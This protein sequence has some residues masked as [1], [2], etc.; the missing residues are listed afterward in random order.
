MTTLIPLTPE[1]TA[2]RLAE[3][4]AVLIDIRG[5]DEFARRHIRDAISL[6]LDTFERSRLA[7][8]PAS[9]VIFTC[10][11]GNRTSANCDRLAARIDRQAYVLEGGTD[12]WV[13]A[14]LPVVEDRKAPLELMR[15]V[16]ITAG[17]LVLLGVI[18]GFA[19]SPVLFGL[20]AFVGAGLVFA[21]VSGWCGMATLLAR[22]PWNRP[23]QA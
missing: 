15:Q 13:A 6:P 17:S 10:R 1:Q 21:G 4:A 18:L 11:T 20:S 9:D 7:I 8:D 16:Q 19:V 3:G 23:A 14:G 12:G 5:P 2:R 22:M